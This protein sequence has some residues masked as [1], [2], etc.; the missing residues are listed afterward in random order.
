MTRQQRRLDDP[1]WDP[2]QTGLE[3]FAGREAD[4]E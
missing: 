4:D 3:E 1:E 2:A